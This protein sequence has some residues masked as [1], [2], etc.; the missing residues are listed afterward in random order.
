MPSN[1]FLI[2]PSRAHSPLP[3]ASEW[4]YNHSNNAL[5]TAIGVE[6]KI[7]QGNGENDILPPSRGATMGNYIV[8]AL[9]RPRSSE[10]EEEE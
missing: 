5:R 4:A 1:C 8:D 3:P 10:K 9:S 6:Q 7:T 2:R